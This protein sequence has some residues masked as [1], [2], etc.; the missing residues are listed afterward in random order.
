VPSG[1]SL[2]L[3]D[4]S[5]R[6]VTAVFEAPAPIVSVGVPT[7]SSY[8]GATS[9]REQPILV[10]AGQLVYKLDHKYQVTSVFT[11]PAAIDRKSALTWY[12]ADTGQALAEFDSP[13]NIS[14]PDSDDFVKRMVYRI[15]GA[16]GL[17]DCGRRHDSRL[18][19]TR[20]ATRVG[21]A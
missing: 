15:A 7:L 18:V 16:D 19:R 11:I 2:R 10:R 9:R 4:L 14:E 5:A 20:A 3:V 8:W 13:P 21:L 1:N 12:E 6:T 17:Q